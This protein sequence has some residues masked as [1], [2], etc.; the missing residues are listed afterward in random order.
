MPSWSTVSSNL[1]GLVGPQLETARDQINFPLQGLQLPPTHAP[2]T[3]EDSAVEASGGTCPTGLE[4]R[5]M[6]QGGNPSQVKFGCTDIR[7]RSRYNR[8]G[9]WVP[10]T[11]KSTTVTS[12]PTVAAFRPPRVGDEIF[13]EGENGEDEKG[14]DDNLEGDRSAVVEVAKL[15]SDDSDE[16]F[17]T[18]TNSPS[19]VGNKPC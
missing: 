18:P 13:S 10:P 11:L 4:S 6:V 7:T 1:L 17:V 19:R 3:L 16:E 15:G 14:D 2:T 8:E 12:G 5:G 9:Y